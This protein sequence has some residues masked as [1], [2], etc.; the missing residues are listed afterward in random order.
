MIKLKFKRIFIGYLTLIGVI[1][2]VSMYCHFNRKVEKMSEVMVNDDTSYTFLSYYAQ[3]QLEP[4]MSLFNT[5]ITNLKELE[6]ISDYIV[7]VSPMSQTQPASYIISHMKVEKVLKGD[8]QESEIDVFEPVKVTS[9]DLQSYEV[10]MPMSW[11]LPTKVNESYVLFL[12]KSDYKMDDVYMLSSLPYSKIEVS[13][14]LNLGILDNQGGAIQLSY[15]TMADIDIVFPM[16][17]LEFSFDANVEKDY[18]YVKFQYLQ[19]IKEVYEKYLNREAVFKEVAIEN[20]KS[21]VN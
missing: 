18:S 19:M 11:Y 9:Y 6:E 4:T 8:L 3:I 13:D 7:L 21:L 16:N 10:V 15:E 2:C 20:E 17:F 5:T 14:V 1:I 12:N